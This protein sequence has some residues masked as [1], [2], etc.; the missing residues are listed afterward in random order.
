MANLNEAF[1]TFDY[2]SAKIAMEPRKV[3][4]MTSYDTTCPTCGDPG[5]A[6]TNDGGSIGGC[7]KCHKTYASKAFKTEVVTEKRKTVSRRKLGET[8]N[9]FGEKWKKAGSKQ[10]IRKCIKCGLPENNHR[11]YHMFDSGE[12]RFNPYSPNIC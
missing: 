1:K 11:S 3:V 5:Y 2:F 12:G 8:V 9:E 10:I 4:Y 6:A 7:T